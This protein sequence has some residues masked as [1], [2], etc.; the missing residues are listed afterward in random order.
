LLTES[1][2]LP[3]PADLAEARLRRLV[4]RARQGDVPA[5]EEIY[6][7]QVGRVFALCRRMCRD[8]HE[9]EE[10]TQETFVKAWENLPSFRCESPFGPWLH[11]LSVNVVL[12]A[13]RARSR[14]Q[15]RVAAIDDF[16]DFEPAAPLPEAGTQLDLER[17]IAALPQG[18]RV[19]FV[20]HDVEGYQHGE[21]AELLGKA[22]GTCKAQLHRARQLLREALGHEQRSA[23]S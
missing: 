16:T 1:P 13:W 21:I 20:L 9:A 23:A 19:V 8:P 5:F 14:Y 4:D 15:K 17:A 3:P 10:M 22:V 7:Q 18:A 2:R 11:R 6:R 12:Q